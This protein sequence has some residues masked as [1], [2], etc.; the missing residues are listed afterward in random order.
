[1]AEPLVTVENLHK[2]FVHMGHELHV[3]RGIDS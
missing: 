3:L 2:T 1:M